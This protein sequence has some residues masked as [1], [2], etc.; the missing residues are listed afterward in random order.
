MK[1]DTSL[2]GMSVEADAQGRDALQTDRHADGPAAAIEA[3]RGLLAAYDAGALNIEELAARA[4]AVLAGA[5]SVAEDPTVEPDL[6][7]EAVRLGGQLADQLIEAAD[8]ADER[9]AGVIKMVLT[10]LGVVVS[11]WASGRWL[12]QRTQRGRS[13]EPP[14]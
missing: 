6:R 10:T 11:A 8:R 4:D 12:G 1:A 3:T 14:V 2:K 13:A 9:R 7:L 5:R